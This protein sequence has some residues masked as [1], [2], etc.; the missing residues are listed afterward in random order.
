[1]CT[2][3][4]LKSCAAISLQ[5]PDRDSNI[6]IRISLVFSVE[7]F[8]N[9]LN[10]ISE[11]FDLMTEKLFFKGMKFFKCLLNQPQILTVVKFPSAGQTKG[12]IYYAS[13][14]RRSML[15]RLFISLTVER[16]RA[17][18]R[19]RQTTSKPLLERVPVHA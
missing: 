6:E 15:Q 19:P 14:F 4:E 8:K 18:L 9:V 5:N 3:F 7:A 2:S 12:F 17:Y 16:S 11:V 1:M 10:L 13:F